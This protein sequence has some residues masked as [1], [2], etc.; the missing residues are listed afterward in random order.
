MPLRKIEE[1]VPK[2]THQIV[3]NEMLNRVYQNR[4][5]TDM[6]D[7][8]Y[9][10]EKLIHPFELKGVSEAADLLIKH[11]LNKSNIMIVGDYDCDGATSTTIAAQGLKMMGAENVSFTVPDRLTQGYGLTPPVVNGI[12][13]K[14]PDLIITVDNGI[15]S[16]EGAEAVKDLEHKCDLLIT[17]HHLPRNDN[18]MP[19]ADAIVNPNQPG[20]NFPSKAIAGCGVAF[21]V[22]AGLRI[23]MRE[24]GIFDMLGI[25]EPNVA[26]L[27]DVLALGTVADVVPL[28]LNNRI[29]IKAGLD[30]INKGNARPMIRHL[31]ELAKREIGQIKATDFGFGIGPRVNAAGRLEDMSLA[32]RGLL[33]DNDNEAWQIAMRLDEINAKRKEMSAN[34]E[35]DALDIMEEEDINSSA[36]GVC[37][38]NPDWHEGIV[39]ILA[40]RV[41]EKLNRPV[42]C[43]TYTHNTELVADITD[44]ARHGRYDSG[45]ENI[46]QRLDK[47]A[48][49]YEVALDSHN[50]MKA[51]FP[52]FANSK[53]PENKLDSQEA[54]ALRYIKDQLEANADPRKI[55]K[56]VDRFVNKFG[57]IKGSCRS[58]EG[59]HLKHT[60]DHINKSHPEILNKFGGHAMAAGVTVRYA[61]FEAFKKHFDKSVEAELTEEVKQGKIQVDMMN[62]DPS[63]ISIENAELIADGGPWGQHF[64]EPA[65][66]GKFELVSFRVLKDKHLKMEVRPQGSDKT[67]DAISFNS[68][69]RGKIP[70]REGNVIDLVYKLD[71]NE[72]RGRRNIQLMV[73]FVQDPKLVL[74]LDAIEQDEPKASA[75]ELSGVVDDQ[76]KRHKEFNKQMQDNLVL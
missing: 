59:V 58:V 67:F 27:L 19:K 53:P 40:G 28:D 6:M 15:S 13:H 21:Y 55:E 31:L 36:S 34:S 22:I 68:V 25:K 42:I 12:A 8:D 71:V 70:V 16:H 37:L 47:M 60:L 9:D 69:E 54:E 2:T 5:V 10:M 62:M 11:I 29:M 3:G 30:R 65:F 57:E 38:F 23:R 20:C 50:R 7:L 73:D 51:D 66:G 72:W 18:V 1:Y 52:E 45:V 75:D 43:L 48:E 35:E 64:W 63:L 24:Q 49:E 44:L 74:E 4:G 32:I 61:H 39:G 17:D 46:N 76:K 14:R 56:V 26:P 41:K 33:S